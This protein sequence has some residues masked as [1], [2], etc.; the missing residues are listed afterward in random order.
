MMLRNNHNLE[1][2]K[3]GTEQAYI[4]V[5]PYMI[6]ELCALYGVTD[7]VFRKWLKPFKDQI[8][9]RL[10]RYYTVSQVETIFNKLG[11]P[12]MIGEDDQ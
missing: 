4:L 2:S 3:E 10:G 5:K 9:E 12:Y 7:K 8:G 11:V 1:I 6:R